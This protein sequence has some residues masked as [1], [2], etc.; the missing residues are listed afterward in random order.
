MSWVFSPSFEAACVAVIASAVP[1]KGLGFVRGLAG[2]LLEAAEFCMCR[3]VP[4]SIPLAKW[5]P[6]LLFVSTWIAICAVGVGMA[7]AHAADAPPVAN[8]TARPLIKGPVPTEV[9]GVGTR[10]SRV[11][12][13]IDISGSMAGEDSN[14]LRAL[15]HEVQQSL[16]HLCK[17]QEFGIVV[18]NERV[19]VL[20]SENGKPVMLPATIENRAKAARFLQAVEP[21]GNARHAE[22]VM[23]AVE[24]KPDAIFLVTDSESRLDL[25]PLELARLKPLVGK[26]SCLIVQLGDTKKHRCPNLSRLATE[27]GGRYEKLTY[28]AAWMKAFP[29]MTVE[30]TAPKR[31]SASIEPVNLI[32]L[33]L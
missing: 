5:Q 17:H 32:Q 10:A 21:A 31:A 4:N 2:F 20:A 18:Y 28:E 22:A 3:K 6:M 26:T 8:L 16:E 19:S 25:T 14:A 30:S 15:V 29:A 23:K 11:V 9:F 7:R 1:T 13:V 27:S 12:Y 33:G 24:L